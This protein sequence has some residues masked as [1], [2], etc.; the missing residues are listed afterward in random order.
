MSEKS[1]YEK[2]VEAAKLV[3]AIEKADRAWKE[4]LERYHEGHRTAARDWFNALEEVWPPENTPEYFATVGEKFNK[5]Y[6]ENR[7][8]ELL[9]MLLVT[10]HEYLGK[11]A[12]NGEGK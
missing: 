3:Y 11:V 12:E 6:S 5:L 8:N 7:G 1:A 4:K 10:T 2:S 9:K